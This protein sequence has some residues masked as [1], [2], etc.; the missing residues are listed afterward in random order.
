M[1]GNLNGIRRK[2]V[3]R[4][5]IRFQSETTDSYSFSIKK[6]ELYGLRFKFTTVE[7]KPEVLF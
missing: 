1:D 5:T 4:L 6:T 2:K 3:E 7:Y